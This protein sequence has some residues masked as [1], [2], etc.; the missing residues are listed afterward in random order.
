MSGWRVWLLR[1]LV[2]WLLWQTVVRGWRKLRPR[3]RPAWLNWEP[4]S[5]L[6]SLLWP[7]SVLMPRVPVQPGMRVLEVGAGTSYLTMALAE[8]VGPAGHITI[9]DENL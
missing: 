4:G 6:R 7:A 2:G 1:L 5:R 8:A 3:S 9:V